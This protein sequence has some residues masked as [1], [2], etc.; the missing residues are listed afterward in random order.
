MPSD[1]QWPWRRSSQILDLKKYYF[2]SLQVQ[3]PKKTCHQGS[4]GSSLACSTWSVCSCSYGEGLSVFTLIPFLLDLWHTYIL[5]YFA[6][7]VTKSSLYNLYTLSVSIKSQSVYHTLTTFSKHLKVCQ[8]ILCVIHC[9]F[10]SLLGCF[11]NVARHR[12]LCL[13]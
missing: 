11:E 6:F 8:K 4:G 2:I 13:F 10:I 9:I 1:K 5:I 7:L 12:L 3:R